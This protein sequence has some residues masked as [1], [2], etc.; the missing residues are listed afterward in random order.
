[1]QTEQPIE[2]VKEIFAEFIHKGSVDLLL[3][4]F[5]DSA[6]Y[7][8]TAPPGTPMHPPFKGPEGVKE[9]FRI[10]DSL[11]VIEQ[12]MITDYLQGG[13]KVVVL[14]NERIRLRKSGREQT[15]DWATVITFADGQI[16]EILVIEDLSI[17][18]SA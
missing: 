1:M 10:V 13:S 15:L 3:R 16:S 11:L 5:S 18:L 2:L 7:R 14:G 6:V 8:T 17:L 12:V 9:Y 4:N